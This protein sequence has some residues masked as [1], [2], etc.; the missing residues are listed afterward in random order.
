MGG[1]LLVKSFCIT[2]LLGDENECNYSK[3]R[4]CKQPENAVYLNFVY[5]SE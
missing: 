2:L 5:F 4:V 3:D 1:Q